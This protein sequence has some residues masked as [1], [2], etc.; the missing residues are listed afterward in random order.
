MEILSCING[1][2]AINGKKGNFL[3]IIEV[4]GKDLYAHQPLHKYYNSITFASES[5]LMWSAL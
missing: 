4:T 1:S 5:M 2:P 3:Q